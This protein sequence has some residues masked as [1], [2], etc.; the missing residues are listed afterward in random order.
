MSNAYIIQ[1]KQMVLFV[2]GKSFTIEKSAL[3]YQKVADAL[4]A[5]DWATVEKLV[6]LSSELNSYTN[7][8]LTIRGNRVEWKGKPFHNA[9]ST[10]LMKMHA[11][12]FPVDPMIN[13]IDRLDK[14][15][16]YRA[17]KELY[18]FLEKN[19]L[20][21]T[22][23][24]KFLAYKRVDVLEEDSTEDPTLK[25]GDYVD[26]YTRKIRNN[27]GD[28][29][30]MDRNKVD[31]DPSRTCSE[32]LH[33]ASMEYLN[34]SGYAAGGVL[35]VVEV[36]PADVVS[37]PED[38]NRQKGRCCRYHVVSEYGG[39]PLED[40]V[41]VESSANSNATTSAILDLVENEAK[42]SVAP[43]S[44]ARGVFDAV[45]KQLRTGHIAFD[46]ARIDRSG[47]H[48]FRIDGYVYKWTNITLAPD[49]LQ[50]LNQSLPAGYT[51][52]FDGM[53]MFLVR[54]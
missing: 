6:D 28:T 54:K 14:N 26:H 36:D 5:G 50:K 8:N 31:D 39:K 29:P 7:G 25:K 43:V 33:F 30:S 18:G 17:V 44:G 45:R 27:P 52:T 12:G 4:R 49:Q 24:G 35:L 9:L 11:E 16:S 15:P 32:G 22:E 23:D 51:L 40:S 46:R 10:R 47:S 1:E 20:P 42:Q 2:N 21:I 37:I 41:V 38:Y 48:Q 53:T 19:Q 34:D 13:F 3:N